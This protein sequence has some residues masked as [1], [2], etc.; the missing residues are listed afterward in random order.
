MRLL[1]IGLLLVLLLGCAQ[2]PPPAPPAAPPQNEL[3][4]TIVNTGEEVTE[5]TEPTTPQPPPTP[6]TPPTGAQPPA[7]QLESREIS[8]EA[9]GWKIYGTLYPAVNKNN[10]T[11]VVILAHE[12]GKT[13]SSWPSSV[14]K[15]IHDEMPEAMVLAIDMRGHGK[16]TNLGAWNDFD[17]YQYRD[18][19]FDI[20]EAKKYFGPSNPTVKEFYAVG[21]SF[22]SSAAVLAGA[23]EKMV[24][25]V[26]MISPGTEYK[27]VEVA[28]AVDDYLHPLFVA[29][30]AEDEYSASSARTIHGWAGEVQS[31]LRVYPGT[32]AHGTELFAETEGSGEPLASA[33]LEFLK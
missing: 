30:A 23:Q 28:D 25:K 1:A 27:G 15:R 26:A 21:A 2:Q 24:T 13:R 19:K 20:I 32:S 31:D 14:I 8:Y 22:G 17:V 33:L 10:P 11:K 3:P 6:P 7:I 18:M 16:S 5:E 12:L 29:A 4:P 9:S